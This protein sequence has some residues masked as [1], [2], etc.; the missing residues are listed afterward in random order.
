MDRR[1]AEGTFIDLGMFIQSILVGARG[2]GLHT[3]GQVAFTKFHTILSK[4]LEFDENEML[5]CGVSMGYED[6]D[7][8]ENKLRVE[9]LKHDQFSTFID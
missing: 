6:E 5:V 3:C 8:P 2:E 7:A 9:K 1:L 4:E